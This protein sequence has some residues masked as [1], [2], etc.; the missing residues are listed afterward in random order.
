MS[1]IRYLSILGAFLAFTLAGCATTK[2][3]PVVPTAE[4]KAQI[5]ED[6]S[7]EVEQS[8]ETVPEELSSAD[9]AEFPPHLQKAIQDAL[10]ETNVNI[11]GTQATVPMVINEKVRGWIH[12]FSV[13]DKDRFQRFLQ[14]GNYYKNYV[15]KV[16]AAYHLPRELYYLA[17]IE[18][19]Y[20][21]HAH[22]RA[23]AVGVWQFIRSTG[24][25]YGLRSDH[26]IDERRDPIRATD[27]AARHLK[28]LHDQYGSWY[29]ALAAYNAGE[30]RIN[31]AIRRGGSR[32]FWELAARGV[33]PR[34]TMDYVPKFLAAVIIGRNTE[35]FGFKIERQPTMPALVKTRVPASVRVADVARVSGLPYENLRILNPHLKLGVTPPHNIGYEIWV[36]RSTA[37]AV[38]KNAAQLKPRR[39]APKYVQYRV[40][41][42]DNLKKISQRFRVSV[43]DIR[44]LNRLRGSQVSAGQVLR[45]ASNG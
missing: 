44:K 38:K 6:T 27:A 11:E 34:E 41:R 28:D 43:D 26:Y 17:M 33:L 12:Y 39:V 8:A 5:N 9:M 40:R 14:R 23:S 30:G 10:K 16:F 2:P 4:L 42:G 31:S 20:Q 22:S 15:Q 37:R 19:G 24:A 1:L 32:D 35:R 21:T 25:R 7:S 13:R 18:S 29:L 3:M 45:I 36:D